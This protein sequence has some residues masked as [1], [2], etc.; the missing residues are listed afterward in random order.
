MRS[1]QLISWTATWMVLGM[2]EGMTLS[3]CCSGTKVNFPEVLGIKN[4]K[5]KANFLER[6]VK[7]SANLGTYTVLYCPFQEIFLI[8]DI[9]LSTKL[10][11]I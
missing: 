5:D 4:V 6:T 9:S 2:D 8:V 7:Y 10:Q 1:G 11:E 3:Q